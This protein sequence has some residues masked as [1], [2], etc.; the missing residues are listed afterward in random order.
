MKYREQ[1][2]QLAS[3]LGSTYAAV[4]YISSAARVLLEENNYPCVESQAILWALTGKKPKFRR[5]KSLLSELD[6]IHVLDDVLCYVEDTEVCKM[7]RKSYGES[8]KIHHL[9]YFYNDEMDVDTRARIRILTRI[10]WYNLVSESI[11]YQ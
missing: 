5:K 11:Y 3:A 7:V 1:F 8:L 6:T 9:I 10:A 4:N 2:D